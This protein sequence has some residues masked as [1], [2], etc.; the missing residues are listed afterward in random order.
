MPAGSGEMA[1]LYGDLD[2]PGPYLV[3]MKWNPGWFSAP[4]SYA[5]DRIQMVMSGTWWVNSGADFTPD[6]AV[7]VPAGGYVKRTARTFHYDGVPHDIK[8]PV[9]IAIFGS[10]R[11]TSG[12]PIPICPRGDRCNSCVRCW[13]MI[14]PRCRRARAGLIPPRS[15]AVPT[16]PPRRP[17]F[18]DQ[19]D[20]NSPSHSHYLHVLVCNAVSRLEPL[21]AKAFTNGTSC[22]GHD[23]QIAVI[24]A[25]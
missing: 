21:E 17:R 15:T 18:S 4:H 25:G 2:R 19:A 8:E 16:K 14:L 9:V 24:S 13:P 20:R 10:A 5:T 23:A 1:K 7:P 6:M 12:L 3:L 11:S 22:L